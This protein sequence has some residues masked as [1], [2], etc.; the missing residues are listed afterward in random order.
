VYCPDIFEETL[1][2]V[3]IADDE[4]RYVAANHAACELFGGCCSHIIGRRID[5]FVVMDGGGGGDIAEM[6]RSFRGDGHLEGTITIRRLDG[7]ERVVHFRAKANVG[8]GQHLSIL[9]DVTELVRV[10]SAAESA[11]LLAERAARRTAHLQAVTE[12]LG[13]AS[14]LAA[15]LEAIVGGCLPELGVDRGCIALVTG[16]ELV[17]LE[18]R[19]LAQTPGWLELALVAAAGSCAP[20]FVGFD[21]EASDGNWALLPLTG[22]YECPGAIAVGC[23]QARTLDEDDRAFL[24]T[25]GRLSAQAVARVQLMRQAERARAE[26]EAA[27]RHKDEF[28]AMLGHELRNPLAPMLTALELMKLRGVTALERE[29]A[30]LSRQVHHMMRLVDDLLDVARI[31]RG[32]IEL[33]R[34]RVEVAALINEAIETASPLL[35]ARE[36]HVAVDVRAGLWVDGDRAR[37]VQIFGNLVTNAAKYTDRGGRIQVSGVGD[38]DWVAVSVHDNGIGIAPELQPR[39][40]DLFVQGTRGQDRAEGGLGI[41]LSLVRSLTLLHGGTVA[42]SSSAE[43]GTELT[44]RLPAAEAEVAVPAAAAAAHNASARRVLVVDDNTDAA[45]LLAVALVDAGHEVRVAHDGPEALVLAAEFAF[46]VALLDL[47]LPAMDGIELGERLR[48]SGRRGRL[49]AVTGYGQECD[50]ARTAAAGFDAH[51]VKPVSLDTVLRAVERG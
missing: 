14:T 23:T 24:T 26:A 50:R 4:R 42:L 32:Q 13:V 5:D 36:H 44:V 34:E 43:R 22:P 37:L 9:R 48:A 19:G 25:L 20:R 38:G 1:D 45:E 7:D 21:G 49:V 18:Q 27:S 16:G 10:A 29:R 31:T 3:L 17:E 11:R 8:P 35:E 33:K 2:A 39:V 28:L 51:L 12:R 46:D 15:V 6:W 40:F 47:G 30:I 41:G